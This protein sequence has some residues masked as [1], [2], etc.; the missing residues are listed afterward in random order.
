M[1]KLSEKVNRKFINSIEL[2]DWEI[3]TDTGW[4]EITYIHKTVS[5]QK[6]RIETYNG[7]TLECADDHIVFTQYYDE[8]F[9]K[10]LIPNESY[11]MTN[12]GPSLV[13]YVTSYDEYENMYDISVNSNNHR[14]YTNG[15]LSHNS[16]MLD[17]LCFVLFNKAFR[18]IVKN[19]L[20]NST[21][22]KECLVEIEFNISNKEYK[23]IRG[24]KPNIFEIWIDGVLQNQVAASNDQQKYLEDTILKLN[25]KSFTQIVIL[26]SASFVPFMQLSTAHRREVVEDLLDIK[27]FSSMNSILK[28]KIKNSN[29]KIKEFTLLE[30]L[31]DEKILMQTEFIEELE[32]RGKKNI[33]QKQNKIQELSDL[34]VS[35][36]DEIDL[37]QKKVI[38]LNSQ[39]EEFSDA[40][41]KLKKLTSLKGKIQQKVISISEE[42]KFFNENSVCSTCKQSIEEEF[43][44]NKVNEIETNSKHLK[45]G[46][47]ELEK[48]IDDEEKRE[49][50]FIQISK[51]ITRLNNEISKDNVCISNYRKNIKELQNEIQ[52]ITEQFENK[53]I[54]TEKLKSLYKEKEDNFK[55]KSKYKETVNYFDFAQ[56]LMKDGGVKSK[57][58][59]KYIP[60]MNQQINKY[61]QMME[62]YI[63]FTLDD[64]FKENIKSPIHEDFSYESFSEG[65]K[66]R[67]NLAI[68]FTW[69]EIARMK[70]SV[71]CNILLFDEVFDSSLDDF[72][73]DYFTKIIKYV[74]KD[75]NVFVI[76]HKNGLEDKFDNVLE[77]KK[78]NGF[79]YMT[80]Y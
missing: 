41:T 9:V 57:I 47:V 50:Q 31:I 39:L 38:T 63:N 25:Y 34:E 28:E 66:M 51:E 3:E 77:F 73:T 13:K 4:K 76:S 12:S 26:G 54:E 36:N 11:I 70:N 40:T 24:I 20:I 59:Q 74:I 33:E 56:L 75:T 8:I 17:A 64:E 53:N 14:F 6:W 67:I 22:E 61:L 58:I 44:L 30:K 16:T 7:L 1:L 23:V 55:K 48:T 43:R 71:S 69:R 42:H 79:S 68:L 52:T 72:G 15:I 32:K 78:R 21:N 80:K 46:Y 5:Y 37:I 35:V 45:E 29:E 65:E 10:N 27:I 60:L 62:F 19:Q 2:N 18:K 49:E